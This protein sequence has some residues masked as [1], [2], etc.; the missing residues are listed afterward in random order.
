MLSGNCDVFFLANDP[1]FTQWSPELCTPFASHLYQAGVWGGGGDFAT[2]GR[3]CAL[4]SPPS[5]RR[6][7]GGTPSYPQ[8]GRGARGISVASPVRSVPERMDGCLSVR[9][10]VSALLLLSG[11]MVCGSVVG[12]KIAPLSFVCIPPVFPSSRQPP[13]CVL[14]Q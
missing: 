12:G 6:N 7:S 10:C 4:S 9:G 3:F 5:A 14:L 11:A 8:G 1:V 2:A 13:W